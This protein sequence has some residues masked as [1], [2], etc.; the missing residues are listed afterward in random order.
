MPK[1]DLSANDIKPQED[2][3]PVDTLGDVSDDNDDPMAFIMARMNRLTSAQNSS[4]G[5]LMNLN[6]PETQSLSGAVAVAE[7]ST[8]ISTNTNNNNNT[9]IVEMGKLV[10]NDMSINQSMSDDCAFES[11]MDESGNTTA[12]TETLQPPTQVTEAKET[13]S[14]KQNTNNNNNET[15]TKPNK[16]PLV[17]EHTAILAPSAGSLIPS[18]SVSN[19]SI[20]QSDK[21]VWEMINDIVPNPIRLKQIE[22]TKKNEKGNQLSIG[23]GPQESIDYLFNA[24]IENVLPDASPD[25]I[26]QIATPFQVDGGSLSAKY[27]SL[28]TEHTG[29]LKLLATRATARQKKFQNSNRQSTTSGMRSRTMTTYGSNRR[30]SS[31]GNRNKKLRFD[32]WKAL[33]YPKKYDQQGWTD[34]YWRLSKRRS[35]GCSYCGSGVQTEENPLT[36]CNICNGV[37]HRLCHDPS[38]KTPITHSEENPYDYPHYLCHFC[39]HITPE[40]RDVVS[41][42]CIICC[43]L[44]GYRKSVEFPDDLNVD[45]VNKADLKLPCIHL[46]CAMAAGCADLSAE[47]LYIE[48][49]N[50]MGRAKGKT[51]QKP[52]CVFCNHRWGTSMP[53][54]FPGCRVALHPYCCH[55]FRLAEWLP[56]EDNTSGVFRFY[57]CPQHAPA[58]LMDTHYGPPQPFTGGNWEYQHLPE[59]PSRTIY[60]ATIEMDEM[61][62]KAGIFKSALSDWEGDLGESSDEESVDVDMDVDEIVDDDD[63]AD[64]DDKQNHQQIIIPNFAPGDINRDPYSLIGR[65][66][67]VFGLHHVLTITGYN[68]KTCYHKLCNE[69]GVIEDWMALKNNPIK[70]VFVEGHP[71]A[72]QLQDPAIHEK[73][74]Q[75]EIIRAKSRKA[76]KKRLKERIQQQQEQEERFIQERKTIIEV[77]ESVS[78]QIKASQNTSFGRK[79]KQLSTLPPSN[80]T[81]NDNSSP[82]SNIMNKPSSPKR[83]RINLRSSKQPLLAPTTTNTALTTKRK[84]NQNQLTTTTITNSNTNSISSPPIKK[85]RTRRRSQN[86]LSTD[87]RTL[88]QPAIMK[89]KRT[90]N[91]C[92]PDMVTESSQP[93]ESL[94]H[95]ELTFSSLSPPVK[96]KRGRPRKNQNVPSQPK[97][98]KTITDVLNELIPSPEKLPI[99]KKETRRSIAMDRGKGRR[100]GRGRGRG[101]GRRGKRWQVKRYASLPLR[102]HINKNNNTEKGDEISTINIKVELPIKHSI[103]KSSTN[104]SNNVVTSASH[105]FPHLSKL[106]LEQMPKP[107]NESRVMVISEAGE[108]MTGSYSRKLLGQMF[109]VQVDKAFWPLNDDCSFI[110]SSQVY[111]LP[112]DEDPLF[113]TSR[114]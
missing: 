50:L 73:K 19:E 45:R 76:A 47:T 15:A 68:C 6:H 91:Q 79:R 39:K 111:K 97:K 25:I 28:R 26:K 27:E 12:A 16:T 11:K 110:K 95:N 52:T 85:K 60:D 96:R 44:V 71:I 80:S 64:K 58:R 72:G 38:G 70:W 10:S 29:F 37:V 84:R 90:R 49:L 102:Q 20:C 61:N 92:A 65:K 40:E 103:P 41:R 108:R 35:V 1:E 24:A 63:K 109:L 114:R 83:K 3:S 34:Y 101:R 31:Y 8:S 53:C 112:V 9:K 57:C 87:T 51:V 107:K 82:K 105:P 99:N 59:P 32:G 78:N 66:L 67:R 94:S 23:Y 54:S 21:N 36:K 75:K 18:I 4:D 98:E 5:P 77:E 93:L 69:D 104:D 86:A 42:K 43:G 48:Q 100:R 113:H 56:N 46:V 89:R 88:S 62:T 13:H 2:S 55:N 106:P 14:Q 22:E 30:I 7:T 74:R 17:H 81:I 33:T